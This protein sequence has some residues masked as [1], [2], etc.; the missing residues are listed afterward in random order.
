MGGLIPWRVNWKLVDW[1]ITVVT[2]VVM[3]AGIGYGW[4]SGEAAGAWRPIR[5]VEAVIVLS[6]AAQ[7]AFL[8][9][10]D[11]EAM[12][13][14]LASY[15]RRLPRLLLERWLALLAVQGGIALLGT[16]AHVLLTGDGDWLGAIGRWLPPT[17]FFNGVILLVVQLTRQGTMGMLVALMLWIGLFFGG[18]AMMVRWPPLQPI[19]AF[20]QAADATPGEYSTNRLTLTVVGL[21]L[22]VLAARLLADPERVMGWRPSLPWRS[23][24]KQAPAVLVGL[25]LIYYLVS[26]WYWVDSQARRSYAPVCCL[27]PA[28]LGYAYETVAIGSSDGVT[29]AGWYVRPQNGAVVIMLHGNEGQR[30]MMLPRAQMVAEYGYG[31]LLYDLRGHGESSGGRSY[32]W[33]DVD[34]VD[35][36]VRYLQARPEV[37]Q[38]GL[39]G[40]S[41]GGQ[42]ALRA[43]VG[44]E[45]IGAVAADGPGF[46]GRADVPAPTNRQEQWLAWHD[47]VLFQALAWRTGE[48]MPAALVDTI[49]EIA[50][51][52]LLLVATGSAEGMERRVVQMYF[53]RAAEPKSLWLLPEASHG[54][55]PGERPV[56]YTERL[57]DFFDGALL[58]D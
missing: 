24:L 12:L 27:T 49:G 47:P 45:A 33:A 46:V 39:F 48:A 4:L 57:V 20:L 15:P 32:G 44:N 19:H 1:R 50:P 53:E 5:V 43:A 29:L 3:A 10:P 17:L 21:A 37:E 42:I 54:G 18:D 25:F 52:P 51:R 11:G 6:T 31:V 56:E 8:L 55:G 38:I 41:L 26:L 58:G 13:E 28:D 2:M 23:R 9:A 34:D 36:A 30:A 16:A 14:L 7:V 40:F 35:A 22:T